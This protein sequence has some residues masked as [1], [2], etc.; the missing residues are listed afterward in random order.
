MDL[1]GDGHND[2]VDYDTFGMIWADLSYPNGAYDT[3]HTALTTLITKKGKFNK[4]TT[5]WEW[6]KDNATNLYQAKV[7]DSKEGLCFYL[8]SRK[9]ESFVF[10][11]CDESS[12]P[13]A[14]LLGSKD[15]LGQYCVGD[16]DG[17]GNFDRMR[18]EAGIQ[19]DLK[20]YFARGDG[21]RYVSERLV[22]TV[23]GGC[24]ME[25]PRLEAVYKP[26]ELRHVFGYYS[27]CG[28]NP[29]V[30]VNLRDLSLS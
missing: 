12:V 16:F 3:Q 25:K 24:L 30:A 15:R 18:M 17:D 29:F 22:A 1:N 21:K 20:L 23:K 14:T 26:S 7:T 5:L 28:T 8:R 10:E 27:R 2:H 6:T 19:Y 13:Q 4:P 9:P 11:Y